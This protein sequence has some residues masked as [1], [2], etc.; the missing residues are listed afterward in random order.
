M[1]AKMDK[2]DL[3]DLLGRIAEGVVAVIGPHCEVVVHD[4][5]DL[6]HSLF[7]SLGI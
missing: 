6:E 1:S 3:Y 4:F 7:T 5:S 2:P